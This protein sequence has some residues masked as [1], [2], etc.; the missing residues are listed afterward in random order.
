M[1][2][3]QQ[4]S[5]PAVDT[6]IEIMNEGEISPVS[7]QTLA[8]PRT[9]QSG[10]PALLTRDIVQNRGDPLQESLP[11]RVAWF[12][13]AAALV[14]TFTLMGSGPFAWPWRTTGSARRPCP[15]S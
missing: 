5:N 4:A 14:A 6:P 11:I 12:T 7:L 10:K 2:R 9:S 1:G 8:K 13:A 3:V 15:A